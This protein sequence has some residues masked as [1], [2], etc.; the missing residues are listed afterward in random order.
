MEIHGQHD[1]RALVDAATHR[2]L[3][4]AFAGLEKDV[5]ALEALWRRGAPRTPRLTTIVP[6]WS[7]RRARPTF[8]RHASDELRRLKPQSGEETSPRRNVAPP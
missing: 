8:L 2:R 6:A 3:L 1:E 5:A 7:A 4:D